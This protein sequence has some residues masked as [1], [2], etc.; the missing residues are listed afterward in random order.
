[1]AK[2]ILEHPTTG[3]IKKAPLGFSWTTLIFPPFPALFRG[4]GKAFMIQLLLDLFLFGVPVF[5]FPFI[6]NKQYIMRLLRE[7]YKVSE[8][9][10]GTVESVS[11]RLKIKL[12]MA[13]K[14]PA[15]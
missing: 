15:L 3:I 4:D 13:T 14:T 12:P 11:R 9:K 2:L 8:V 6:Y 1:M 5:I 7:G 10:R